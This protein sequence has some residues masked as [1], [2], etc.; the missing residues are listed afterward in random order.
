M[1]AWWGMLL[2]AGAVALGAGT[3]TA[4]PGDVEFKRPEGQVTG[5]VPPATFPHWIHQIRYRCYVCHPRLFVM[6]AGANEVT[7]QKMREGEACGACHN[8]RTAFKVDF[9]SCSRCHSTPGQAPAAAPAAAPT[10]AVTPAP[11]EAGPPAEAPAPK[12]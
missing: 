11:T 9:R 10:Q 6:K 5:P 1:K 4:A 3:V 7:M 2:I 8:G 12:N